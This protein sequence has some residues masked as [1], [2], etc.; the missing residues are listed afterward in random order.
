MSVKQA[1]IPN[2]VLN[3]NSKIGILG[4]GSTGWGV[5]A[6]IF[7]HFVKNILSGKGALALL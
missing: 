6:F 2:E 4:L 3:N 1:I 7:Q 5:S